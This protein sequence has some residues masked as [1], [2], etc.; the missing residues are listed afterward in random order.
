MEI[1]F[2]WTCKENRVAEKLSR[3]VRV[4]VQPVHGVTGCT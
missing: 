3:D 1:A 2:A 4:G